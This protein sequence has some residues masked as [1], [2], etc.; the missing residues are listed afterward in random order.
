[1]SKDIPIIF[2][3]PMVRAL[4]EGRKT[5]TRRIIKLPTKGEYVRPDMGGWAAA[6]IG[7]GGAFKVRNMLIRLTH[8]NAETY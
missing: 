2:S 6:N 5:Q 3:G 4:Q 1:M 8:T 7:G